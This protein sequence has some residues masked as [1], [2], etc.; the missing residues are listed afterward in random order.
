MEHREFSDAFR[1]SLLF[2]LSAPFSL[3]TFFFPSSSAINYLKRLYTKETTEDDVGQ[4]LYEL[5]INQSESHIIEQYQVR[6]R[7]SNDEE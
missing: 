7:Y 4:Q 1:S 3:V 6:W 2:V 5:P